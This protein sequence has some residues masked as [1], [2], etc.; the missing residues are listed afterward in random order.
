MAGAVFRRLVPMVMRPSSDS[1]VSVVTNVVVRRACQAV[2]RVNLF[3]VPKVK[4]SYEHLVN[5]DTFKIYPRI[6]VHC[7]Q[8]GEMPIHRAVRDFD[9]EALKALLKSGADPNRRTTRTSLA[10]GDETP[11]HIA[12]KCLEEDP[13]TEQLN[14]IIE[15]L[16][17]YGANPNAHNH[18]GVTPV[19]EACN[20]RN[21]KALKVLFDR[22]VFFS[23]DRDGK[24]PLHHAASAFFLEGIH[25]LVDKGYSI[26]HRDDDGLTPLHMAIIKQICHPMHGSSL[27]V[28]QELL[29]LGA[30]PNAKDNE[31]RN[32]LYWAINR[33]QFLCV[34]A[35]LNHP[36]TDKTSMVL[37]KRPVDYFVQ[38]FIEENFLIFNPEEIEQAIEEFLI[39]FQR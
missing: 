8:F 18:Y 28:V 31:G 1:L 36:E 13:R 34:W 23:P 2:K 20:W 25:Q 9:E 6:V 35:L 3:Q 22:G 15:I 27:V 30:D 39:L 12:V 17:D 26:E 32:A 21:M 11:L 7:D 10:R 33:V 29:S 38:R 16:L 19:S 14:R 24:I 5:T 4:L 37:G